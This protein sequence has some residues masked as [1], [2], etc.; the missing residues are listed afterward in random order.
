MFEVDRYLNIQKEGI[1]VYLKKKIL[2]V[3]SIFEEK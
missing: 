1:I 2:R 3:S